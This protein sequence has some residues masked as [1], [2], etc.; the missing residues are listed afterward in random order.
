LSQGTGKLITG[1]PLFAGIAQAELEGFLRIFQPVSFAAGA[2]LMRQGQPADGAYII[3]SGEARVMTALPGGG[4]APVAT[5]GPG[6]VLGEMALLES[7]TRSAT[8][9]ARS[10]V[11]AHF[12]ERDGFRM[13]LAQ[14]NRAA[15]TVQGRI[16]LTLCQRLRELNSKIIARDPSRGTA[17]AAR[18]LGPRGG[19]RGA[20]AFDW[21]GFLPVL[22]LFRR[23]S[24]AEL[25]EF[26]GLAQVME[27]ARG[28]T[29]FRH[30]DAADA[31]H[32]VVRGAI[33]IAG[34]GNGQRQ[35]IGILGPGRLCGTLALIEG[36]R[37]SMSASARENTVL[38]EIG[39]PA[40]ERLFRG[41]DR[42]AAR[43]QEA[44]NQ[45]LLQALGRT[46]NHLTRLVSQALIRGGKVDDLQQA[47]GTQDCRAA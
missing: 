17:P 21:R 24:A 33:E 7:G 19:R 39:Q 36:Q 28:E 37:H 2:P 13:L 1:I 40:F 9:I 18:E 10:P 31:C 43:F 29:L 23:Y 26:A 42:L 4:E 46:N 44:I 3:E 47:L 35:R 38:L 5:L 34:A 11:S 32:V 12:I 30:G 25:D 6:S 22:P 8:V 45:E 27:L 16:T 14:R 20:G 41:D 15:F